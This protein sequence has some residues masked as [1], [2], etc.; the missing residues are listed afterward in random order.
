MKKNIQ[1]DP[2]DV[3]K[4]LKILLPSAEWKLEETHNG[5]YGN[6]TIIVSGVGTYTNLKTTI[7]NTAI[8]LNCFA[9]RW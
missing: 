6:K 7:E 3:L 4:E 8:K 5:C 9:Q 2:E 1:K